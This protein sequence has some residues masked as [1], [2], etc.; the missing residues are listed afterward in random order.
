VGKPAAPQP[1]GDPKVAR[2]KGQEGL[3]AA[4]KAAAAG[5][6]SEAFQEAIAGWQAVS[7]FKSDVECRRLAA[8]LAKQLKLSGA[9][10]NAAS[11]G[12]ATDTHKTL[13]VE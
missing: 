12:A 9:A 8:E 6:H 2:R 4:K 13:V 7:P 10:A 1:K 5:D 11:A 3:A